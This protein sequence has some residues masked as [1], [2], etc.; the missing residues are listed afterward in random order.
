MLVDLHDLAN[1]LIHTTDFGV[2]SINGGVMN[3][4]EVL[5]MIVGE[6]EGTRD[7]EGSEVV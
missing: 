4:G 6:R 2:A 3:S 7:Q 1:P 5:R